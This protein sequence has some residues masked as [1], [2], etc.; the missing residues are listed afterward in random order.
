MD[1]KSMACL[2]GG[3]MGIIPYYGS[4]GLLVSSAIISPKV[5][6]SI[7]NCYKITSISN[8]MLDLNDR[9]QSISLCLAYKDLYEMVGEYGNANFFEEIA[10]LARQDYYNILNQDLGWNMAI[11][12][13]GDYINNNLY[14]SCENC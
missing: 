1:Y 9:I 6:D 5:F 12:F 4:F 14:D 11:A 10:D 7:S 8:I 2:S 3:I 13:L